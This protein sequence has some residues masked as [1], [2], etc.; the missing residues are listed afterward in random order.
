MSRISPRLRTQEEGRRVELSTVRQKLRME[1]V[2]DFGPMMIKSDLSQL[3]WRKLACIQDL[4][5]ARQSVK[6]EQVEVVMD[7]VGM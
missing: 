3:R 2:L 7:L 6:V 5:S 1:L 4:M